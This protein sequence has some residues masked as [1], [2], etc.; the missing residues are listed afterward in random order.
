MATESFDPIPVVL[1]SSEVAA[2]LRFDPARSGIEGLDG[3][4]ALAQ[5]LLRPRALYAVTYVGTKGEGTVEIGGVDFQSPILRSNLEAANK[6]FPFIVTVGPELE[7]AAGAQ[8]DLLKQYYL[9]EMANLA[10]ESAAAWLGRELEA[11]YGVIGLSSLSPGSLEDW[12]LTEQP[13][14]FA[15]FGDTERLIGVRLTDSLLMVPRKSVSG[16]FFPSEEGF[17]ACRLCER[18]RCPSR[19]APWQG[20]V[21]DL[22]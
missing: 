8:S 13:K 12:P 16:L 15:L 4:I 10:L 7:G 14:L 1:D 17:V 20:R 18:E 2:R 9:E 22:K 19:K 11:R 6:V 5:S 21:K 3:L